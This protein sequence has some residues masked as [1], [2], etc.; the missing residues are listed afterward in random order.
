MAKKEKLTLTP[1]EIKYIMLENRGASGLQLI[2]QINGEQVIEITRETDGPVNTSVLLDKIAGGTIQ[3]W[4]AIKA[5][6][7]GKAEVIFKETQPW[8]PTFNEIIRKELKVVV[9]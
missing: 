6:K 3:A 4:F 5:I 1:G 7:K 2:F 8:N 9:T